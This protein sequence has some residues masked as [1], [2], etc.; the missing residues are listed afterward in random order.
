[1]ILFVREVLIDRRPWLAGLWLGMAA[2]SRPTALFAAAF[3]LAYTVLRQRV[4]RASLRKLIPFAAVFG[5]AL[6]V[7]LAYNMIRFGNP[8]DFG[9]A[10]VQGNQVLLSLIHI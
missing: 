5:S 9:Y 10:F 7:M 8:F 3:Y 4:W 2:L 1:M 6:L